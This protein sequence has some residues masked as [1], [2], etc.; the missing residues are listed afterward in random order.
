MDRQEYLEQMKDDILDYIKEND[1]RIINEEGF[2][3]ERVTDDLHDALWAND[4]VTGNGSGSYTFNSAKAKENIEGAGDVIRDMVSDFGIEA[5]E[6]VNH[7][8]DEDYEWFDVSIRCYLLGE[9]IQYVADALKEEW[10]ESHK[11]ER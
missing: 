1:I 5:E 8:L 6:L 4:N 10:D 11:A 3:D 7:F 9:A 2:I